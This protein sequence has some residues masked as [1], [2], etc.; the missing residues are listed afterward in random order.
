MQQNET[1]DWIPGE[2]SD[3]RSLKK[4]QLHIVFQLFLHGSS[5]HSV[6][7]GANKTLSNFLDLL[8]WQLSKNSFL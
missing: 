7:H 8:P 5:T 6:S 4:T 1:M 2:I 3:T